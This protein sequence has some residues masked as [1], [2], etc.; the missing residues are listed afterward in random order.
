MLAVA[1]QMTSYAYP[2]EEDP[3]G[4]FSW[5]LSPCGGT[6][7]VPDDVKKV[8]HTLNSISGGASSYKKPKNV[9]PKSGKKGDQGNPRNQEKPRSS[10]KECK[11]TSTGK[12]N[13]RFGLFE[14]TNVDF[15]VDLQSCKRK[16]DNDE[17]KIIPGKATKLVG[18]SKNTLRVEECVAKETKTTEYVITSVL[19]EANAMP[20]RVAATCSEHWGQA[21]F[22][23]SSVIRNNPQWAVLP[24]PQLA[25][26][27]SKK[28]KEGYV[29]TVWKNQHKGTGWMD[30][31]YRQ[32]PRCERDEYPPA[33]LLDPTNPIYV[34][35]GKDKRGQMHRYLPG[36]QNGGA[37]HMWRSEC[38]LP[39]VRYLGERPLLWKQ[40]VDGAPKN[41]R[42]VVVQ[43]KWFTQTI[44]AVPVGQRPEFSIQEWK[45]KTQGPTDEGHLENPCWPKAIAPLDPGFP[46]L[47][48]D[49]FYGGKL[50]EYDY[51]KAYKP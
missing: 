16:R 44:A 42:R 4:A 34:W 15:N 7:L 46:L 45:H 14:N 37:A 24:C 51:A 23:Y 31:K 27:V 32:E 28:R 48:F 35:S 6:N 38:F 19:Y 47:T 43:N 11:S 40:K 20:T 5:W 1:A 17:C 39:P 25:A 26:T 41:L 10:P 36:S 18:M 33:Y 2:D 49:S 3:E 30:K 13:Q 22:H 9:K 50:P 8:F 12:G 29:V 21:C